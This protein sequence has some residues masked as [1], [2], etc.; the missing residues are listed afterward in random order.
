MPDGQHIEMTRPMLRTQARIGRPL[1][2]YFAERYPLW[3]ME[4]IAA[5][6]GVSVS[7]VSRW[8]RRLQIETRFPGQKPKAVA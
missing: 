7:S 6:L 2:A 1:G 5:D 3:T 4:E 8:M